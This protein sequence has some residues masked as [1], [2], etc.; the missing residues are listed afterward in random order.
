MPGK[1]HEMKTS[2]VYALSALCLM[3]SSGCMVL[4]VLI[5]S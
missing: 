5:G 2:S 4:V 3:F 1:R